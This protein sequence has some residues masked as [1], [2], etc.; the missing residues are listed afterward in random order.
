MP[1]GKAA[2]SGG[3]AFV[4]KL[5]VAINI[6][7]MRCYAK[8]GNPP[9]TVAVLKECRGEVRAAF[10]IYRIACKT[11]NVTATERRKALGKI[12][13][14]AQRFAESPS[15]LWANRLWEALDSKDLEARKAAY[16]VLNMKGFN[17]ILLKRVLTDVFLKRHAPPA[18]CKLAARELANLDINSLCPTGGRWPDPGLADLVIALVPV[19]K[20]VTGRTAGLTSIDAAG[21]KQCLFNE[22]LTAMHSL[23]E[24]PPPLTQRVVD[25]VRPKKRKIKLP[26]RARKCA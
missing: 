19:W 24:L 17:P 6:R 15:S 12:R 5:P 21:E 4:G 2:V 13:T 20:R 3:V 7:S 23:L 1:A 16:G 8:R 25:I 26:R 22:W 18:D 9:L 10:K 14:A 11:P